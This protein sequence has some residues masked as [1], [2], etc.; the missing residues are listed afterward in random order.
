M[1]TPEEIRT[2]KRDWCRARAAESKALRVYEIIQGKA[3]RQVLPEG[4]IEELRSRLEI[5]ETSKTGL[6][7]KDVDKNRKNLRGKPAGGPGGRDK[8]YFI[9]CNFCIQGVLYKILVAHIVW[10]LKT[11]KGVPAGFVLNHKNRIR[12]DNRFENLTLETVS[13]NNVN[14]ATTGKSGYKNVHVH[15]K[16]KYISNFRWLGTQYRSIV[17]DL[18]VHAC[19]VYVLGWEL[20]TSGTVPLACVKSQTDEYLCGSELEKAMKECV[21][22]D[23]SITPPKYKTLHEYIASVEGSC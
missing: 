17:N 11:N 7:W 16:E 20:L 19:Y 14:K 13:S 18:S 3:K 9:I 6:R 1:L 4:A 15:G 2:K 8:S 12:K 21:D 23:I 10:M 22:K 5:D